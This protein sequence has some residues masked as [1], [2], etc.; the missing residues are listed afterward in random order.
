MRIIISE[1]QERKLI[2]MFLKEDMDQENYKYVARQEESV[3]GFLNKHFQIV[4]KP[5]V[6]GET[7]D[8]Y[9]VRLDSNGKPH[10]SVT[11]ERLFYILQAEM[12]KLS[13]DEEKRDK[14]ISDV[15]KKW[16]E[17]QKDKNNKK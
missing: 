9:F 14:L 5:S 3:K 10:D 2:S 11:K 13:G 15:L 12:P 4:L 17:E 1:E 16:I 7:Q 6:V 8:Y